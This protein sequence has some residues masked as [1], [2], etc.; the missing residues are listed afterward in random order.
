ML[1]IENLHLPFQGS[2]RPIT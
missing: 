2:E 1:Q